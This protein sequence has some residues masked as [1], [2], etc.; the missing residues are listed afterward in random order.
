[1][2]RHII[3]FSG[4][5]LSFLLC[6]S[7]SANNE[8][9]P[10]ISFEQGDFSNW[11][12]CTGSFYYDI[13]DNEFKYEWDA[14]LTNNSLRFRLM[15]NVETSEPIIS[16]SDFFIVPSGASKVARIGLPFSVE[17]YMPQHLPN[18]C[19]HRNQYYKAGAEKLSYSFVVTENSTLL[20]CHFAT[21]LHIP[22]G[23]AGAGDHKGPQHPTFALKVECKTPSGTELLLPCGD[24]E[25]K[26]EDANSGLKRNPS[27]C[28]TSDAQEY[29]V[30]Y[31]YRDWTTINYD[32]RNH[33]GNTITITAMTHDCLLDVSDVCKIY[34]HAKNVTGSHEAYGYIYAETSKLEMKMKKNCGKTNPSFEAP[35]GFKRYNWTRSDSRPVNIPDESKPWIAEISNSEVSKGLKVSCE[36]IN[37][38]ESCASIIL[39]KEVEMVK[40]FPDFSYKDSCGGV[41]S[42]ENLTTCLAD[43]ISYYTW[44]FGDSTFAYDKNPIHIFENGGT[45]K[46][47]LYAYTENGCVDSIVKNVIIENFPDLN[48]KGETNVCLDDE[49]T[50]S[51]SNVQVG[52]VVTWNTGYVGQTLREVASKSQYYNATITD[53]RSCEYKAEVYVSVHPKPEIVITGPTE[54]C[55]FDTITMVAYNAKKYIWNIGASDSAITISPSSTST[56]S[57]IGYSDKGCADTATYTVNVYPISSPTITGVSE[58]CEGETVELAAAGGVTYMW[59]MTTSNNSISGDTL[60]DIPLKTTTYNLTTVDT[61]NCISKASHYVLVKKV[62]DIKIIGDSLFCKG[63][64]MVLTANG[65]DTYVWSDGSTSNEFIKIAEKAELISVT[66]K[67]LDCEASADKIIEIEE[68]P[69]I[70]FEGKTDVCR[71][72]TIK[73]TAH[74]AHHYLWSDGTNNDT[75]YSTP[76]LSSTYILMGF[77]EKKCKSQ[78]EIPITV[79]EIPEL[80]IDGD[81]FVCKGSLATVRAISDAQYFNWGNG[82]ADSI[83]TPLITQ[84]TTL[85][86]TAI[87]LTGCYTK[88]TFSIST[89]DPPV[90]NILGDTIICY[91]D[92]VYL[93]GQ[94]A[95]SYVWPDGSTENEYRF[96]PKA[97]TKVKMI[98]KTQGCQ[99]E[100]EVKIHLNILPSIHIKGEDI[101][102]PGADFLLTAYGAS[103]YLWSTS[104]T[105][106]SISYAPHTKTTYSVTGYDENGCH[107]TQEHVID[108][109]QVPELSL[110][111]EQKIGC[112]TDPDTVFLTANGATYYEW[113]STPTIDASEIFRNAQTYVAYVSDTTKIEVKGTDLN[114]CFSYA[115]EN[116]FPLPKLN[117]NFSVEPKL[118]DKKDNTV[119]FNGEEP[120]NAKWIWTPYFGSDDLSG[121]NVK[122]N[123]N[124][125]DVG[126][127]AIVYV[128][129]I[130]KSGCHYNGTDTIYVWKEFW[131]PNAF[132]PNEDGK[133]ETFKFFGGR[134]ITEFSFIIYNRLE[135]VVFEGKSFDDEW[136]GYYKGNPCPIGVYGWVAKYKSEYKGLNKSGEEKGFFT[137]VK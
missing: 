104:D 85:E 27:D 74:G 102:C 9:T 10:N 136:D 61:N 124:I 97:D 56:Y 134:Y 2:L 41:V 64:S 111:M 20:S 72:D 108:M 69:T 34:P 66:G 68:R 126:D 130:D 52:N 81:K 80:K 31:A 117:F 128:T 90:I 77:S 82:N 16:C 89:I 15:N 43:T 33:I 109:Y 19:M 70:W 18:D 84:D 132:T 83:Y 28:K 59:T 123:Y 63:D 32:L 35:K 12:R 99:T 57:V 86:V 58:I 50:L 133:N 73:L 26:A 122:Y 107:S 21:V 13:S 22:N 87:N 30:E 11:E 49:F 113:T 119:I 131:A 120:L 24:Y 106:A 75:M 44:D 54:C 116:V 62:P 7:T 110:S 91:G 25:A 137:I 125:N 8:D 129:A 29:A 48:I 67:I 115:K 100:K 60:R 92:D 5:V 96:T 3:F 112:Y 36:M 127:S 40:I 46:V 101:I 51:I 79:K 37:D 55:P 114:G 98:G 6:F 17:G 42:F 1:M 71:F 105:T 38:I 23:G 88:G 103:R 93:T 95:I 65:A 121:N 39:E 76:M 53:Q 14:P 135:Q 47:K 45:K 118:I 78:L 4:L 94:G